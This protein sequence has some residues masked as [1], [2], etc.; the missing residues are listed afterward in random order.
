MDNKIIKDYETFV[1]ESSLVINESS[2]MR[3]KSHFNNYDCGFITAF[4][5]YK[6]CDEH[7]NVGEYTLEENL[8]RN[9]LLYDKLISDTGYG[10]T[11]V[12]GFY[13]ENFGASNKSDEEVSH[14]NVFFVVDLKKR[15]TLLRDLV[16]LG[17]SCNQDSIL[18]IPRSITDT[19]DRKVNNYS[20]LPYPEE[21]FGLNVL[22]NGRIRRDDGAFLIGT[23]K[24]PGGYPG[25]NNMV[26]YYGVNWMKIGQFYTELSKRPFYFETAKRIK[27]YEEDAITGKYILDSYG[28]RIPIYEV[29]DDPVPFDFDEYL[30]ISSG[31]IK[32]FESR[33]NK[34]EVRCPFVIK[35]DLTNMKLP[36]NS[37]SK[38]GIFGKLG[39]GISKNQKFI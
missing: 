2:L 38:K 27:G 1:N 17:R 5:K 39:H 32:M 3:L 9:R 24:C 15:G 37:F 18:Y 13:I 29:D 25:Y 35:T 34:K 33:N 8:K 23:N 10:V 21:S 11:K 22:S 16:I 31:D 30:N 19:T 28:K 6:G 20:D 36:E 12:D 7:N 26:A 14:E 4:R